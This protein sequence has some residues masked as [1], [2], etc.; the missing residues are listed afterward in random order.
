M[1]KDTP[2]LG[3]VIETAEARLL[4][5]PGKFVRGSVEETL[6]APPAA[7]TTAY[8]PVTIIRNHTVSGMVAAGPGM[9]QGIFRNFSSAPP[10]VCK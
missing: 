5:H 6:N 3:D 2:R 7:Q 4:D 10:G 1:K 9:A 8:I